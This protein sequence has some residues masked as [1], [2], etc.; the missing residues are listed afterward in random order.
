MRF[1]SLRWAEAMKVRYVLMIS[2]YPGVTPFLNIEASVLNKDPR[3]FTWRIIF[4]N[5]EPSF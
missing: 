2:L 5:L 1:R 3:A 4:P